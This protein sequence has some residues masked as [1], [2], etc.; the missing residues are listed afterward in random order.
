MPYHWFVGYS[1]FAAADSEKS[2]AEA[3]SMCV[4]TSRSGAGSAGASD[5]TPAT[6]TI[7]EAC[8]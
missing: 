1:T 8:E 5:P 4:E 3:A 2:A 7:I 6:I